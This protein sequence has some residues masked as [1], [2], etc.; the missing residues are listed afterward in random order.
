MDDFTVLVICLIFYGGILYALFNGVKNKSHQSR[1]VLKSYFYVLGTIL[2]SLIISIAFVWG[3]VSLLD[4]QRGQAVTAFGVGAIAISVVRSWQWS[5]SK[6]ASPIKGYVYKEPN[7]EIDLE[8][9]PED[10]YIRK[11]R[12]SKKKMNSAISSGI[13]KSSI[14]NGQLIVEDK[15]C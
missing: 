8:M 15:K 11:Y 10:A 14:E 4:L 6:I 2:L 5:F 13:I 9:I 3:V 12:I 7:S 1:N